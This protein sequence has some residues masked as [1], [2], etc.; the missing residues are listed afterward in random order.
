MLQSTDAIPMNI[1]FTGKGNTA[2]PEG[3]KEASKA[4]LLEN[5][6][7]LP[8]IRWD[9][10]NILFLQSCLRYPSWGSG[11]YV[12]SGICLRAVSRVSLVCF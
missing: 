2:K 3:L 1:G 10:T 6:D 7:R 11:M 8:L 5:I 4:A 9:A 12:S